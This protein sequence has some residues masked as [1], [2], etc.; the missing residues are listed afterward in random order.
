MTLVILVML[1]PI[2]M[3]KEK[4]RDE[5]YL[6]KQELNRVKAMSPKSPTSPEHQITL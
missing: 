6:S 4:R 2:F 5:N 1:D 3:L